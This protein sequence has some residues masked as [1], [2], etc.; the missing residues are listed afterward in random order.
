MGF[1]DAKK[2]CRRRQ[3]DQSGDGGN[4]G[5]ATGFDGGNGQA[6]ER[7]GAQHLPGDIEAPALPVGRLRDHD[8]SQR[9]R[10]Q[11]E[12]HGHPED[13]APAETVDQHSADGRTDRQ[14]EPI[15][16]GPDA[17]NLPHTAGSATRRE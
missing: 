6:G 2:Q 4:A 9:Q 1:L 5:R 8:R 16:G 13:A 15:A 10:S 17:Q 11:P 3:R 7:H 14:G 12:R